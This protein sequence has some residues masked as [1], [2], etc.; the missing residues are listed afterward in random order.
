MK[1]PQHT[2]AQDAYLGFCH[3]IRGFAA[4]NYWFHS[5]FFVTNRRSLVARKVR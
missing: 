4:I 2:Y 1:F 5:A 3:A